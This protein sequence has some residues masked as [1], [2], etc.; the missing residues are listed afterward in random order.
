MVSWGCDVIISEIYFYQS[1]FFTTGVRVHSAEIELALELALTDV[2]EAKNIEAEV[3]SSDFAAFLAMIDGKTESVAVI[4]RSSIF[5]KDYDHEIETSVG[6]SAILDATTVNIG[7]LPF[8]RIITEIR[9]IMQ[10]R[11]HPAIIPNHMFLV[12]K[13]PT[14]GA[15]MKIS[16]RSLLNTVKSTL[17]SSIKGNE[18]VNGLGSLRGESTLETHLSERLDV[19][20]ISNQ[21]PFIL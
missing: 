17:E 20:S 21:L 12:D 7:S 9:S 10:S 6:E 18:C 19:I 5:S 8:S 2:F 15:A 13:F 1:P 3:H 14:N 16:K 4:D 11:C